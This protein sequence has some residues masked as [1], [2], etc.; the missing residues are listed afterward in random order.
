MVSLLLGLAERPN[1][2][3]IAGRA[4]DAA[5]AFLRLRPPPNDA[6]PVEAKCRVQIRVLA[7]FAG[8]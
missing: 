5:A 7:E 3:E 8:R 6:Q 1:P 4:L 2:R